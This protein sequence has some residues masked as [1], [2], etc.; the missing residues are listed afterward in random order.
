MKGRSGQGGQAGRAGFAI[1]A[2]GMEVPGF[3]GLR[4]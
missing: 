3:A 1:A 4:C 2:A